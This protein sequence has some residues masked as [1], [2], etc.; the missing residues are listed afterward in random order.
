MH[1]IADDTAEWLTNTI[2]LPLNDVL[3]QCVMSLQA[4]SIKGHTIFK[5]I[6]SIRSLWDNVEIGAAVSIDFAN[7]FPTMSPRFCEAV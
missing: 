5:H 2:L 1:H 4:A 6:F 3:M 7:V